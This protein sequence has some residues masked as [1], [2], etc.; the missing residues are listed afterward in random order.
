MRRDDTRRTL[1]AYD[2]PQDRTRNRL[3]RRLL[4]YGDRVQYSVF[5][6]DVSPARL[7]RLKAEIGEIIDRSED[8]VLFCDLGLVST[9]EDGRFT[10]MGLSRKVTDNTSIIV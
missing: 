9:V 3:A 2:V 4:E 5:V 10:Y 1:V 8:S 7:L 6:V